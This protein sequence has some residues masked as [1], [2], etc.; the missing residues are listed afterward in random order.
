LGFDHDRGRDIIWNIIDISNI[1]ETNK[2][3]LLI[4]FEKLKL[5]H[6]DNINGISD[7]WKRNSELVF[8]TDSFV[9]G[10]IRQHLAKIGAQKLKIIKLWFNMILKG[11]E[12]LHSNNIIFRDL[13]CGRILYNNTLSITSIG[14]IFVS[15]DLFYKSFNE[16]EYETFQ[17]NCMSPEIINNTGKLTEKSDIYSLGMVLL[18]MITLEKPYSEINDPNEVIKNVS[19]HINCLIVINVNL[20]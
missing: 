16:L 14:D 10:S 1:T 3:N 4:E 20:C 17:P 8:I 5:L 19:V 11:L 9:G 7:V 18:E 6:H 15:S 13:N 2:E 12:Y